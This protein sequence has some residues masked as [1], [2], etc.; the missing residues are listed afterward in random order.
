LGR[1]IRVCVYAR[2]LW[3]DHGLVIGL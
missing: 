2:A 1:E 3:D